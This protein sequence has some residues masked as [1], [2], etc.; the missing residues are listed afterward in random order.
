M[1][2]FSYKGTN[3]DSKT[4][5]GMIE[6]VNRE[7]AVESLIKQG[8]K[9]SEIT[10]VASS[11]EKKKRKKKIKLNDLVI[12]TRQL[13]T[14]VSAGV[15]LMRALGTLQAQSENPSMKEVIG[16]IVV[17]VEGGS[18]LADALEKHPKVFSD[19]YVNMV[20]AGEA[21]GIV[22]DILKRLATQVEKSASMRKKIK[23]AMSYP[24]VLL[25]ITVIA[26]F[27]IMLFIM[28]QI[29][30][31]LKGLGG[32]DAELPALTQAMLDMS[33][34]MVQKWWIVLGALI[35]AIY[36]F[37]TYIKTE[38]GKRRWHGLV[39]KLPVAGVLTQKIAVAS[40]TRTFSALIGAGVSM[41]EAL[42]V[43]SRSLGNVLFQ[44][45]LEKAAQDVINGKQLSQAL[46]GSSLF[47][48]IVPQ[49]LA[50]GEE[51]GQT[52]VVLVKVA[53]FYEEEV[54]TMIDSLSSL[55]E[56]IMIVV[57]GGGVGL[58]AVSVMGPIASLSTSVG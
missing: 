47:P 35:A 28:P 10:A 17:D 13:A 45:E 14:M 23:G 58:I 9:V 12:F 2:T 52:D 24:M 44:E 7:A 32:P 16:E 29:G 43:T 27:G 57:L 49:M 50:V 4:V 51:T 33:D 22:D 5:G 6:S 55:L 8:L 26:F 54:D 36:A 15:P 30:G 42:K 3:N 40:F 48:A 11:D 25:G 46:T 38:A 56:P 20:R 19:I 21:A 18:Q 31:I 1:A 41:V 39:L 34:F 37:R 53:E